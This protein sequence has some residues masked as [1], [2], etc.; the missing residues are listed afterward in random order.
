MSDSGIV[1]ML[2]RRGAEAG[3]RGIHAHSFR[4]WYANEALRS[5]MQEG[6]VMA[7]AGWSS[8][9]MLG[10]YRKAA[11]A[12]ALSLQHAAS[13]YET[14]C[15][16]ATGSRGGPRRAREAADGVHQVARAAVLSRLSPRIA[17]PAGTK[18]VKELQPIEDAEKI[19]A[20]LEAVDELV[21]ARHDALI[22]VL[23][24]THRFAMDAIRLAGKAVDELGQ[25][26]EAATAVR[27]QKAERLERQVRQPTE[28][29]RSLE[30][31]AQ[32]IGLSRRR[33]SRYRARGRDDDLPVT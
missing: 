22:E 13:T 29:G 26:T 2:K 6:E 11:E 33:V 18:L 7:I 24:F 9:E 23:L 10:R 31:I 3:V 12:E 5:G 28:R 4:H 32:A 14:D 30:Q 8:R 21:A 20:I 15:Q 17:G 25:Q 19:G 16:P 27:R 1:Q